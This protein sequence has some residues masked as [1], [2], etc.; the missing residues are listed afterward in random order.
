MTRMKKRWY[1][2]FLEKVTA[3]KQNLHDNAIRFEKE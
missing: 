2:R 1:E 3:L